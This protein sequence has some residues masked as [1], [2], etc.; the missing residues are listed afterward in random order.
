MSQIQVVFSGLPGS[1]KSTCARTVAQLVPGVVYL[2]QDAEKCDFKKFSRLIARSTKVP[3][4]GSIVSPRVVIVDRTNISAKQRQ[5]V[6]EAMGH[7]G[8]RFVIEFN[9][10]KAI[11][12]SR[13]CSR[14]NHESLSNFMDYSGVYKSM[15]RIQEPLTDAEISKYEIKKVIS[16][17]G[18]C[19]SSVDAVSLIMTEVFGNVVCRSDIEAAVSLQINKE[20]DGPLSVPEGIWQVELDKE[21]SSRLRDWCVSFS[22]WIIKDELHITV[23]F[24]SKAYAKELK[25]DSM[26]EELSRL[27]PLL[28]RYGVMMLENAPLEIRLTSIVKNAQVVCAIVD[29]EIHSRLP[30][31]NG[32]LHIT[33]ATA[34]GVPPVTAG[35]LASHPEQA[36]AQ[37]KVDSDL[38]LRGKLR[39]RRH[40]A[41]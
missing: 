21:S 31:M 27:V 5:D 34:P 30:S 10:P 32:V 6:F 36:T 28:Q 12:M 14:K 24:V 41:R 29:A 35:N 2:N 39:F 8:S 4:E 17:D 20:A 15:M 11:C 13:L 40:G 9:I 1:G 19:K 23:L 38:R 25:Q 26:R 7:V 37:L 3:L 33:M 18:S 16:V 22:P